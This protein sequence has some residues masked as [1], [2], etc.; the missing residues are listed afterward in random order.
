MEIHIQQCQTCKGR[1]V[2]NILVRESSDV[3]YVQ[4]LSC[5]NLVAK[6]SL[7]SG[8]YFHVGKGYESYLRSFERSGKDLSTR[9]L[10][11]NYDDLETGIKEEF[12]AWFLGLF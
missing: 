1:E 2:R 3:V 7:Q 9:N 5:K 11:E 6:Y 8:G 12:F 4:C 10:I